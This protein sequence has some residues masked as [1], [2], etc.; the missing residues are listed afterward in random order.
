MGPEKAKEP[1]TLGEAGKQRPIVAHQPA[2]ERTIAHTFEGMEQAQCHDFTGPQ[3]RV[4]MFGETGHLVIDLAEQGGDKIVRGGHELLRARQGFTFPTSL[5]EVHD[6]CK[7][8]N[9]HYWFIKN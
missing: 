3:G 5:E 7:A 2:I 4:G 8:A 1:G 9:K 6:R